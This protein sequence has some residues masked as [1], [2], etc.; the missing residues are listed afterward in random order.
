[1]IKLNTLFL[2]LFVVGLLVGFVACSDVEFTSSI[3]YKPQNYEQTIPPNIVDILVVLDNSRSM[4]DE[5]QKLKNGFRGFLNRLSN[6]DYKVGIITTYLHENPHSNPDNN[7]RIR[8]GDFYQ[9]IQDIS[10]KETNSNDI[11]K[12]YLYGDE[13]GIER[14]IAAI[15]G[16]QGFFRSDAELVVLFVSDEDSGCKAADYEQTFTCIDYNSGY[17]DADDLVTAVHRRFGKQKHFTVHSIVDT[18]KPNCRRS[19]FAD[20]TANPSVGKL[21][22]EASEQTNGSVACIYSSNYRNILDRIA[23]DIAIQSIQLSCEPYENRNEDKCFVLTLP[24]TYVSDEGHPYLQGSKLFFSPPLYTGQ[25]V[26][27]GYWCTNYTH[28]YNPDV[29]LAEEPCN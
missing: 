28:D 20:G 24:D 27:V 25:V 16:N 6:F 10:D 13:K 9:I 8:T 15:E 7:T 18:G 1:M 17:K 22:M 5:Q 19:L 26:S 2:G 12:R 3:Q 14:A 4:L 23:E 11:K 29:E 21:Y